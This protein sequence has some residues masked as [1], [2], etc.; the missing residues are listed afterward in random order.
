MLCQKCNQPLT[1]QKTTLTYLGHVFNTQLPRCKICGQVY[2][3]EE[4]AATR[5]AEVETEM[6]DK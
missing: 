1:P 3:S 5:I 2:I 4:L 6:E